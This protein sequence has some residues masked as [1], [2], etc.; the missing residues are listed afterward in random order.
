MSLPLTPLWV[1]GHAR[2]RAACR[3]GH[4]AASRGTPWPV[5][6]VP[7]AHCPP[8]E[9]FAAA[10][11]ELP[12]MEVEDTEEQVGLVAGMAKVSSYPHAP[13]SLCTCDPSSRPLQDYGWGW[14]EG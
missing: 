4:T 8:Q 3:S 12:E 5:R 13:R 11:A 1:P 7:P 14:A 10:S 9:Y 2:A 6:S